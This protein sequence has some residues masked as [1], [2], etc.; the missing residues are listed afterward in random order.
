MSS[1]IVDERDTYGGRKNC[2]STT[3]MPRNISAIKKY[4]L[5]L[6][7]DDSS[8]SSH[9]LGRGRRKPDGGGPLGVAEREAD[10]EKLAAARKAVDGV[11]SAGRRVRTSL[12]TDCDEAIVKGRGENRRR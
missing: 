8:D 6:S 9:R 4:L 1:K 2:S 10:D 3:Y 11:D 5:A 7:R 12:A